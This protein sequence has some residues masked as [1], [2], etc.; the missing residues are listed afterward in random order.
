MSSLG[1]ENEQAQKKKRGRTLSTI[2]TTDGEEIVEANLQDIIWN[3]DHQ[4]STIFKVKEVPKSLLE[5]VYSEIVKS[6]SRSDYPSE[7]IKENAKSPT[8]YSLLLKLGDHF[9][10]KFNLIEDELIIKPE[11]SLVLNNVSGRM[12]YSIYRA[13]TELRNHY[14]LQIEVKKEGPRHGLKQIMLY[15]R[16]MEELNPGLPVSLCVSKLI[17]D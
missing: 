13:S 9:A 10:E 15:L 5:E 11:P 2:S 8:I 1:V 17:H 4:I 7:L 6:F 3:E 14:L 16:R 12:D